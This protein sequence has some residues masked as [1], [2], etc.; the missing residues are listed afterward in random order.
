M[1]TSIEKLI[2]G[3]VPLPPDAL[4]ASKPPLEVPSK[5]ARRVVDT[6]A[7]VVESDGVESSGMRLLCTPVDES[8]AHAA[9]PTPSSS[10]AIK[11]LT[12][13]FLEMVIAE[14]HSPENHTRIQK[15]VVEPLVKVVYA[16]SFPYILIVCG[17]MLVILLTSLSTCTMFALMFFKA[18]SRLA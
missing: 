13:R 10:I 2:S 3:G 4:P 9:P 1:A 16:H 8:T 6:D 15:H 17:V 5:V 7:A 11:N 18:R 14:L 12:S